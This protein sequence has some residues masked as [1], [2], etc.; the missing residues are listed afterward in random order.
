MRT[1]L[2][3]LDGLGDR[4]S[5]ILENKTPLE[6][7]KTPHLDTFA[8]KSTTG[9]ITPFRN[10]IPLG[11]ETAHFLLWGYN[12]SDFPGRGVIEAL[13]EDLEINTNSIYLRASFGFISKSEKGYFVLDR[14]TKNI[15]KKEINE[16]IDSLPKKIGNYTFNLVYSYDVH[17]ILEITNLYG[18]ISD[19]ISDSDPFYREKHVL[20]VKP[21]N[22]FEN[23]KE[24]FSEETAKVLNEYLLK[25]SLILENHVVNKERKEN[26]LALANFLLTKWAGR[27]RKLEPFHEKWGIKGAVIAKSSVFKGLSKLIGMDYFEEGNFKDAFLKGI[28]LKNY[29][30]IHIHT[31]EP[32]EA[33]HTKNPISKVNTLE[34]IDLDL[35]KINELT[36]DLVIVT[37][38]HSTPSVGTLIHSGEEIPVAI[39]KKNILP[40]EVYEFNE[41]SCYRGHLRINSENL[42]PLI[43][44][45]MGLSNIS[46]T[47]FG[48]KLL[49]YV[50]DNNKTDHLK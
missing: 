35:E 24:L 46:G 20:K 44:N 45:Y 48:N 41:K 42:M 10:G 50:P 3:L 8:K 16:L 21:L 31:K 18:E 37:S 4:P 13:G 25:C 5:E 29:D 17:C 9:M 2:I 7:A 19:K 11:T 49:K 38:D 32:D 33:A 12:L 36:E 34:K 40:D 1:L 15:F 27:Y 30:F 6:Y 22:G 39:Y 14:R 26:G 47:R 28:E 23:K 43:L